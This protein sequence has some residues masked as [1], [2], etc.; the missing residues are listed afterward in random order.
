MPRE[1]YDRQTPGLDAKQRPNPG[2]QRQ[3]PGLHEANSGLTR[4]KLRACTGLESGLTAVKGANSGLAAVVLAGA[5]SGVKQC[6]QGQNPGLQRSRPALTPDFGTVGR[7]KIRAY[8]MLAGANSGVR[9]EANSG[10]ASKPGVCPC[11]HAQPRSLPPTPFAAG[12]GSREM[13]A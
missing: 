12:E 6:W 11:Q 5:E 7:G 1:G 8:A 13:C 10:L 2:L 4:G 3:T 9:A